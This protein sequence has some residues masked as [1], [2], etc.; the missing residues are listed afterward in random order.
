[1]EDFVAVP[2]RLHGEIRRGEDLPAEGM[3][4]PDADRAAR[5]AER[6]ERV[7]QPMLELLRG[8]LVE[9][10][11]R[12]LSGIRAAVHEPRDPGDEGRRLAAASG[13]HAQDGPGR[14]GGRREL[15][16][17]QAGEALG[18]RRGWSHHPMVTS[19]AFAALIAPLSLQ[20]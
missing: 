18:D 8:T 17:C 15:V 1:A 16:G 10:D 9:G 6:V 3:E 5:D 7:A 12:D 13:S 11:G 4:G 19:G 20:P 14:G 2:E